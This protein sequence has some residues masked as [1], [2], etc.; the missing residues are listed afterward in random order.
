M[1]L[2]NC[3][4]ETYKIYDFSNKT[5]EQLCKSVELCHNMNNIIVYVQRNQNN[6]DFF[7]LSSL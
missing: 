4:K 5:F 3:S 1:K 7:H 2:N 6:T